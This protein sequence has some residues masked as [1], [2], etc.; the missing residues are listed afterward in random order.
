MILYSLGASSQTFAHILGRALLG[1][2][3]SKVGACVTIRKDDHKYYAQFKYS[4]QRVLNKEMM[5]KERMLSSS[6]AK[7]SVLDLTSQGKRTVTGVTGQMKIVES[8]MLDSFIPNFIYENTL[9]F[10]VADTQSFP[11]CR[12]AARRRRRATAALP[13]TC[14]RRGGAAQHMAAAGP[15]CAHKLMFAEALQ[16]EGP[17]PPGR[18]TSARPAVD[19][20]EDVSSKM[21]GV[22]WRPDK[23]GEA[24]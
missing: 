21:P 6:Q 18:L 10:H 22:G 15:G 1:Q 8:K 23:N 20:I 9:S 12:Y 13:L 2:L 5:A 17:G 16:P 7:Q 14:T 19:D 11:Y 3:R 24:G 4:A